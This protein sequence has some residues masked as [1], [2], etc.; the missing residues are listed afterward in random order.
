MD[1]LKDGLAEA[2]WTVAGFVDWLLNKG[3][4]LCSPHY[5]GLSDHFHHDNSALEEPVFKT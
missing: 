5:M 2:V 1:K 3:G 4:K